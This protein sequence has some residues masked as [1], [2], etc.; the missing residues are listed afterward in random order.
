VRIRA[1][2]TSSNR[3][4]IGTRIRVVLDNGQTVSSM[5]KTGSGYCSQSELPVTVGLGGRTAIKSIEVTWPTG[6]KEIVNGARADEAITIEEGKGL[7]AH[8]PFR[9]GT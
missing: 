4:A 6:R 7:V 9:R 1:V 3:D 8:V 5:V 2:G